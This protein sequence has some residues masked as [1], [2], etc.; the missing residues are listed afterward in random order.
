MWWFFYRETFEFN[1]KF[2]FYGSSVLSKVGKHKSCM[3]FYRSKLNGKWATWLPSD[4]NF[5]QLFIQ[6]CEGS[7]PS[8]HNIVNY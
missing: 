1:G 5:L 3:G 6:Y 4:V 2:A 7:I 8:G